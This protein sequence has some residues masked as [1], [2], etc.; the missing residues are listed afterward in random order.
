MTDVRTALIIGGGIA[1]PVTA[2]ALR[3]AGIAATVYEAHDSRADGIGGALMLAPNGLAALRVIGAAATVEPVGLPTPRMIMET[4]TGKRLGTFEDL[5]GVPTSRTFARP[6]LYAALLDVAVAAGV[7]VEYG[8]RLTGFDSTADG[9]LARFADGTTAAADVLV[10]ADGIRSTV[11][12]LLDPAAP[13]PRSVRLL[14]L[15]GWVDGT[16]LP[17]TGG[18]MHL[19]FGRRAFFG[20]QVEDDGRAGW[21]ANLPSPEPVTAA[22]AR[23]TPEAEWLRRL[24]AVYADDTLPALALLDRVPEGGL[25]NVG[26]MQD[27]PPVPVWHRGRAVLVGDA[28]HA[29]SPSSG[30]GASLAI[31]S[32]V[33]LARCLRDLPVARAFAA[34]EALRRHR[35]EKIIKRTARVN[36][37]KAPGPVGRLIRDL[38]FPL[39]MRTFYNQERMMGWVHRH[40]IDWE[41]TVAAP[42]Q[43]PVQSSRGQ[44]PVE[45]ANR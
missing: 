8:K 13:Q 15:G 2:I 28:A 41:A 45:R 10:G 11:R 17:G 22:E 5:P 42:G 38:T 39:A 36:S 16:G 40:T 43:S 23:R 37:D 14:G 20:Y 9:V 3:R 7:H 31:E 33:E 4:G 27:M 30:Q 12:S 19:A 6:D 35:V 29:T 34:Y 24:R 32:A 25:V 18:A 44:S 21:F 1:G 26:T